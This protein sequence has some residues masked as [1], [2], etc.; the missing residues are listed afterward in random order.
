[1]K[2]TEG[3]YTSVW[4]TL[5]LEFKIS[6]KWTARSKPG[7]LTLKISSDQIWVAGYFWA[8]SDIPKFY[9]F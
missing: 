9:Y 5:K 7:S 4:Q 3:H 8:A 2:Y 1:M 6:P